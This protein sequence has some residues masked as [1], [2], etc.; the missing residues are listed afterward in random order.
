MSCR[1]ACRQGRRTPPAPAAPG[2]RPRARRGGA[3]CRTPPPGRAAL[4]A[5][6]ARTARPPWGSRPGSLPR[7]SAPRGR[8]GGARRAASPRRTATSPPPASRRAGWCR[9]RR[10]SSRGGSGHGH[11]V[12]PVGVALRAA[13]QRVLEDVLDRAGDLARLARAD[14][15][16]VDLANG[17]QL[18]GGAGHEDLVGEVEL[19]AGDLALLQLEAEV[20]RDLDRRGAVDAA[21][22]AREVGRRGDHPVLDDEQVLAG[23]LGDVP[24]RVEEDRLLVAGLVGL[25]LGEHGVEVLARRL[26]GGDHDVVGQP[27]P[28]GDAGAHAALLALVAEV[29]AP[30]PDGDADLDRAVERVQAHRP[31]AAEDD[32]ADVALLQPRALDRLVGG[33]ADLLA[34]V[35]DV[36]EVHPGRAEQPLDVVL[37][38]EDRGPARGLVGADAL[39]DARPVVQRVGEYV[40]LGVLVGNVLAVHPDDARLVHEISLRTASVASAVVAL[41]PRSAVRSPPARARATADSTA[42]AASPPPH[43]WPRL[44]AAERIIASGL[45]LPVP[46]M[47][48]AEPWTGSNR[49]GP[50]PPSDALGSMPS[51]PVSIAASSLRMS[52][53]MF[54]VRITSKWRGAET[55]CIAALSTRT[56]SSST[57]G[58]S[59]ACTRLTTS[60]HSRLVSRTLALSTL[61]TFVR[62]APNAVRAMRSISPTVY[63]HTSLAL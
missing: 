22:H 4:R 17:C 8:R 11:H 44:S 36:H 57:W 18:G 61:A 40:H 27:A 59:S 62:A 48:G 30:F 52:P 54:S 7:S 15:P 28:R 37:V 2:P 32:R 6:A 20:A 39:E 35:G 46:A 25:D 14:R 13:V 60:R 21:E 10:S 47:S 33:G 63:R 49:P 24:V 53:N 38:A 50:S 58:N 45:A 19:I 41:P 16:V 9:R 56:C 29:G 3:W 23:A 42:G 31:G 1:P 12:V 55:S 5:R 34:R 43:P 26:G 51:E